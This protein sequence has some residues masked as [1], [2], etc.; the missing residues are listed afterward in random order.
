MVSKKGGAV[1]H[2]AIFSGRE[3]KDKCLAIFDSEAEA[4]ENL[5]NPDFEKY[6]GKMIVFMCTDKQKVG[7][8]ILH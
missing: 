3:E 5:M 8:T 4:F 1:K 6:E 7:E 2:Y